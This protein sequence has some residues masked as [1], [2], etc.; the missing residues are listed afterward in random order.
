LSPVVAKAM[1]ALG[2]TKQSIRQFLWENA[3]ISLEQRRRGGIDAWL[4]ADR[5]PVVRESAKLE[6]WPHSARP[7]NLVLLVAGGG[8]P[9]NSYWMEGYSPNVVGRRIQV[10]AHFARLLDQA[11]RDIGCGAEAC[12]I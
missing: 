5:N 11:D 12:R 8:H 2:W 4:E 7:E 9:T 10:P 1:A 6:Q 3:K